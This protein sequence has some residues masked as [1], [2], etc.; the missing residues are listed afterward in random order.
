M[1]KLSG[2]YIQMSGFEVRYTNWMA[3]VITGA[4]NVVSGFNVHH[5]K[6]NGILITGNSDIVENSSVW[7][8]CLSNENG[9]QT[10]QGWASGLS[11]ARYPNNAIIRNNKVYQ[12]WGEGL[13]TY[14]ANGTIIEGNIVYDNY[15]TNVY[16][17]DATNVLVQRN[18]IY[19]TAGSSVNKGARSGI[20]MGDERYAP[21]SSNIRILNNIVFGTYRNFHWWQGTKGGGMNNVLI[22][23]NTFVN[24]RSTTN[25]QISN[26]THLNVRVM[27][28]IISQDDSLSIALIY[29]SGITLSNNL[30]SKTPG[31]AALGSSSLVGDPRFSKAG[32]QTSYDWYKLLS[33]SPATD[34]GRALTE[35]TEDCTRYRRAGTLDIGA[36]E[37]R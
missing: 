7:M 17:S 24:S 3:V 4:N 12:N 5:N 1:L 2:N 33:G 6:E 35:V 19:A 15:A 28:N 13:S 25:F 16:I 26:G 8:N 32:S 11:A 22:A 31:T 34:K 23:N 27:N 21:A 29:G 20:M 14:E 36:Y 10:R 30:W 9:I 18:I 37:Y